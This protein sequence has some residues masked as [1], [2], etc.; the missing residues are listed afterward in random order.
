MPLK[1]K[2]VLLQT[3]VLEKNAFDFN[4]KYQKKHGT[5]NVFLYY[6]SSMHSAYSKPRILK[7]K[8]QTRTL[9]TKSVAH[10]KFFLVSCRNYFEKVTTVALQRNTLV[11]K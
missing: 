9:H 4:L 1:A 3:H 2:V 7:I 11:V 10:H 8:P 6:C 5:S